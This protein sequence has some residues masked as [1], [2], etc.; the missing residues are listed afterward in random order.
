MNTRKKTTHFIVSNGLLI[1]ITVVLTLI[2]NNIPIAGVSI[3]LALIPIAVAAI[4][5]G[6]G[7][8]IFVGLVNGALVML[9]ASPIFS[10]NAPA[11]VV[12]CLLKSSL[13]GLVAAIIYQLIKKKNEH[14]AV[15]LA[16]IIVPIVNTLIFIIGS[17]LFFNGIL[18]QLISLFI[19]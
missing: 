6:K 12:V 14:V 13:A 8:G 4:L 1:A 3:N 5:Y 9:S 19:K 15:I 17:L 10:I 11:T 18:G 7:S 16:V 2:S